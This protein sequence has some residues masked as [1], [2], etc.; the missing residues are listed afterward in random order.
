MTVS[1]YNIILLGAI[2]K[3]RKAT[4]SVRPYGTWLPMN[5]F[6]WNFIFEYFSKIYQEKSCFIKTGQ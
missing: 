1:L 3:L 4:M 2:V 5:G 6:S